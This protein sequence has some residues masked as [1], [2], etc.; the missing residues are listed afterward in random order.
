MQ[1]GELLFPQYINHWV[2][3]IRIVLTCFNEMV[4][5]KYGQSIPYNISF[6]KLLAA[7]VTLTEE[8]ML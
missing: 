2:N 3:T 4:A 6:N 5:S 1:V 8:Y 7:G